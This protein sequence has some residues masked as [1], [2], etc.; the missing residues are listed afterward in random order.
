MAYDNPAIL[1]PVNA[2]Q[3]SFRLV[4]VG[5]NDYEAELM[6]PLEAA[7]RSYVE[8]AVSQGIP[9]DEIVH[10][11]RDLSVNDLQGLELSVIRPKIGPTVYSALAFKKQVVATSIAM[12]RAAA[13][14]F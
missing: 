1:V 8:S 13:A 5:L 9:A 4:V 6:A 2:I 14:A 11:L 12:K 3:A 7:M 10:D